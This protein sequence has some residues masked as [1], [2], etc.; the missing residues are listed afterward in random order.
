M[1]LP[2]SGNAKPGDQKKEEAFF[3]HE[4]KGQRFE[5]TKL[6]VLNIIDLLTSMVYQDERR[7]NTG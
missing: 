4:V 3:I 7:N 1:K 6:E 2:L 5:L